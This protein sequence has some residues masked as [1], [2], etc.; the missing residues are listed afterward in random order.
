[1]IVDIFDEKHLRSAIA[2]ASKKADKILFNKATM[3]EIRAKQRKGAKK[4]KSTFV[5]NGD[6]YELKVDFDERLIPT[7]Y[8]EVQTCHG[9]YR[10]QANVDCSLIHVYS[11]HFD[12]RCR[13]RYRHKCNRNDV[14]FIVRKYTRGG[15]EYKVYIDDNGDLMLLKDKGDLKVFIT[16]LQEH[17][18]KNVLKEVESNNCA[19][20]DEQIEKYD[21]K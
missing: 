12:K 11:P 2:S 18:T 21:L 20:I 3:V 1:M 7:I 8:T 14:E 10:V 9:K 17:M 16:Y 15:E 4:W 13:E 19:L 5:N 6:T